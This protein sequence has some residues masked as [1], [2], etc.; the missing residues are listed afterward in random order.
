MIE[1]TCPKCE[2][3]AKGTRQI[4]KLFGFRTIN[5]VKRPQSYCLNDRTSHRS[6]MAKIKSK[7]KKPV[8]FRTKDAKKKT[9]RKK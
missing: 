8:D 3:T 2:T 6:K 1:K 4:T 5:G 7:L 9:R